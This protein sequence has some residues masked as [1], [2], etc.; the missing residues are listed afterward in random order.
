MKLIVA[1]IAAL[2]LAG[3]SLQPADYADAGSTALAISEGA[4]ELNPVIGALGNDYAAPV[5]LVLTAGARYAIDEYAAPENAPVYHQ[6]LTNIKWAAFCNNIAVWA[7]AEPVTA[8]VAFAGCGLV[9]YQN[10]L[11]KLAQ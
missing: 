9:S 5:S 8:I 7:G 10:G 2:S 4:T 6:H 11:K 1:T 3:C